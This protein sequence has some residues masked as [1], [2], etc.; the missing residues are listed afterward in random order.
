MS[1]LEANEQIQRSIDVAWCGDTQFCL[2]KN[3]QINFI[4]EEHKPDKPNE[5]KRIEET[6]GTV[7]FVSEA[8]RINSSLAVSRSFGMDNKYYFIISR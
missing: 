8:W 4:T 2:V 6:G 1:G 5:K 7:N 3:G